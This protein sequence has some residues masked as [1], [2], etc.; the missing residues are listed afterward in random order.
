MRFTQFILFALLTF[1][2]FAYAWWQG[3]LFNYGLAALLLIPLVVGVGW[4]L[5][6]V[7]SK[8]QAMV[9]RRFSLWTTQL[10][11]LPISLAFI[12]GLFLIYFGWDFLVGWFNEDLNSLLFFTFAIIVIAC[13]SAQLIDMIVGLHDAKQELTKSKLRIAA[14]EK[15]HAETQ[16]KL[17]QAQIEPHFLFNTLSNISSLI[18]SSPALAERTLENLTTL[19]RGS[20]SRTREKTSTLG[21]EFEFARAYLEIQVTRMQGRLSY[22]C[23]LPEELHEIALPP[24]LV[25]PL[26]ENAAI[27]G[28]EP[29]GAGGEIRLSARRQGEMLVLCVCDNGIGISESGTPGGTGLSNV[30]ERLRLAYGHKAT[31]ELSPASPSGV[32]ATISLPL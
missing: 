5:S 21:Q 8:I 4:S 15:L 6:L 23:D 13:T 7:L 1:A 29:K 28:I 24:L 11:M 3:D 12:I 20:L 19:L 32:E 14:Q 22:R 16:L 31:L 18:G 30:R 10:I 17:L 26:L 27:H 9:M 2:F 25:Q